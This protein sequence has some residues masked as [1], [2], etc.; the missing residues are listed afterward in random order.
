VVPL[1]RVL[2]CLALLAACKS[3]PVPEPSSADTCVVAVAVRTNP[4]RD[5]H[6]ARPQA[7]Y[8][9]RCEGDVDVTRLPEVI[10]SDYYADG[11]YA[12]LNAAPGRYAVVGCYARGNGRE[13]NAYF[14]ATLIRASEKEAA[15]GQAVVLG[16][17]DVDLRSIS[18]SGDEAQE[19]YLQ[20]IAPTWNRRTTALKLFTRDE[21]A[22][23]TTWRDRG[24][25]GPI[26]AR[27]R[28]RLGPAWAGRFD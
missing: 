12:L 16:S 22:W 5:V 25:E 3:A 2:P 17:F 20:V 14:A 6:R 18:T 4:D 21:H 10:R 9:V 27:L 19:H 1:R 28:K 13:W 26:L 24:D 15:P 7:V 8:F 23:G 11:V